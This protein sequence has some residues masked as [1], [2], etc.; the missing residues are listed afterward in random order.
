MADQILQEIKDRLNIAEVIGDYIQIKKAGVNYKTPCPFHNEKSPSLVISPAKQIW[1]C[2]GCGEGGDIFGFVMKYENLEFKDALKLLADKAGVKLP[3]WKQSGGKSVEEGD[4][5]LRINSFASRFFHEL[6][7][8]DKRGEKPLEYLKKRGLTLETIIQWS[9]GYAPNEFH[10][11]EEAL[12]QK[13]VTKEDLVKAGV[14]AKNERGQIYD[15]FRGRITFPIFNSLGEVVGFSARILPSLDDGKGAKYI[16]SP[17]TL[18]YFKSKVLFGFNFAKN[19]IRKKNEVVIVEGQMDCISAHQAGFKNVVASSGTALTEGHLQQLSRLTKNLKF[20]FDADAAGLQATKRAIEA[21]LG[22]DFSIKIIVLDGAKDP[23]ELIRKSPESFAKSVKNARLFLDY[24][25]D[26]AFKHYG[27]FGAENS[28]E[29]KKVIAKEILPLIKLL[30]DPLE[31]DHYIQLLANKFN[32]NPQVLKEALSQS[33]KPKV[34]LI[35]PAPLSPAVVVSGV[36]PTVLEK[37]IIGG[38]IL[39]SEFRENVLKNMTL[40]DFPSLEGRNL[41]SP[42]FEGKPEMLDDLSPLAK[43]GVFMV[44]SQLAEMGSVEALKKLLNKCFAQLRLGVIKQQQKELLGSISKAEHA[45]EREKLQELNKV[46]ANLSS[47]R[48]QFENLL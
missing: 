25:I 19:E 46:F 1:H 35:D 23:D 10:V 31:Q 21:Y 17:E 12:W 34:A 33:V 27:D 47:L 5:L 32:T 13:K 20:C 39:Y 44:E 45:Q 37:Q 15:R 3:E 26:M 6:L 9:I 16:N 11:L 18:I 24:Y 14:S 2:F 8:K 41:M 4:L 29:Q 42:L 38:I 28:V 48:I 22:R 40:K 7:T 43:E 36:A 30:T